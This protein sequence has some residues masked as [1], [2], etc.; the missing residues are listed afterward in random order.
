[1][2]IYYEVDPKTGKSVKVVV[3]A[4]GDKSRI[5]NHTIKRQ[6]KKKD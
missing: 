1:M 5:K 4:N 2:A 6:G 3:N